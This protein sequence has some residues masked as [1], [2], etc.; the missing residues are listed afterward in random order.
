MT[1]TEITEALRSLA[2][3]YRMR[4]N[5]HY[6]KALRSQSSPKWV[7]SMGTEAMMRTLQIARAAL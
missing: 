6:A 3:E 7:E 2:T 4:G 1:N 5:V